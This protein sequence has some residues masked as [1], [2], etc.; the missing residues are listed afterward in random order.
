MVNITILNP[1][2]KFYGKLSNN[3]LYLMKIE[4]KNYPSVTNYIYSNML[5]KSYIRA[6]L[7]TLTP[8]NN[9]YNT[10]LELLNL[11]RNSIIKLGMENAYKS[12][13][14]Q[15]E[16]LNKLMATGN[17]PLLYMGNDNFLGIGVNR[18]GFNLIGK[19]LM[20]IRKQNIMSGQEKERE[21]IQ[22]QKDQELYD[23]YIVYKALESLII[24]KQNNLREFIGK[25]PQEIINMIGID[26]VMKNAPTLK[27]FIKTERLRILPQDLYIAVTNPTILA[28]VVR[29]KELGNLR[30]AIIEKKK[31]IILEMYVDYLIAK[32]LEIYVTRA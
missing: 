31:R 3:Y 14:S 26:E 4:K 5:S 9:V 10:F 16:L 24:M 2:D 22:E 12:K 13:F 19:Y 30:V 21:K 6:R 27:N 17:A 8:V 7:E 32:N 18:N 20:Q 11:E 1:N 28:E 23:I 25:T 15:P 29:K